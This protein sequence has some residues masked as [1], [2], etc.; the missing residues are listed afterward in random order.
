MLTIQNASVYMINDDTENQAHIVNE[1]I[2]TM[3]EREH[4]QQKGVVTPNPN[5]ALLS[6]PHAVCSA[7]DNPLAPST[8]Q[9]INR[10]D[11]DGRKNTALRNFLY[12]KFTGKNMNDVSEFIDAV[13][14]FLRKYRTPDYFLYPDLGFSTAPANFTMHWLIRINRELTKDQYKAVMQF[15]IRELNLNLSKR[16]ITTIQKHNSWIPVPR[17]GNT[18]DVNFTKYSLNDVELPIDES[19]LDQLGVN[20]QQTTNKSNGITYDPDKLKVA[21]EHFKNQA[22]TQALLADDEER[23]HFFSSIVMAEMDGFVSGS[24]SQ[25]AIDTLAPDTTTATRWLSEFKDQQ[26]NLLNNPDQRL[27]TRPIGTYIPLYTGGQNSSGAKNIAEQLLAQLG[28]DFVADPKLELADA[29]ELISHVYPPAIIKQPGSDKDNVVIFN[30]LTGVWTHDEDLFYSLLT[31]IR[32][33]STAQQL[34]TLMRTFAAQARNA[35]RY[36]RPYSGSR[37]LLF[38]NGVL[39]IQDMQLH[40]VI[41]PFVRDLYFTERSRLNVDYVNNPPLPIR[42]GGRVAGGDW[43]P[44]DFINAYGNN[45]P[46]RV[47][48][49]LFGLSLGLFGGHNFGVHFDIQGE[50]R[51]GKTT[52]SEIFNNLYENRTVIIS[53]TS[54]NGRFPFT[55]YP[56]STSIIWVKECNIGTDPLSDEY[57]TV[58]YDGLADNQVRFE[59]KGGNDIVL[60]NPPQVYIDGT[61][62]I[63]AREINTG[64]AGR[65]LA[66]KLPPMTQELRDQAYANNIVETLH[67]EDVTQWLVYQMIMAY[68][69][70]I[71]ESRRSDLKLN[72]SVKSDLDLL[73]SFAQ[74]WRREFSNDS[75]DLAQWFV[76]EIDPF[77]STDEDNPTLMHNRVL[78]ELYTSAYRR[79]NPHDKN[80]NRIKSMPYFERQL[81]SLFENNGWVIREAGNKSGREKT[82]RKRVSKIDALNFKWAEYETSYTRPKALTTVDEASGGLPGLFKN[83]IPGWFTIERKK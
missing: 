26:K 69:D 39:D 38:K 66:Y 68:R 81:T 64:P 47:R 56:L 80:L 22:N 73:P 9:Q 2:L 63:Q 77:L 16:A 19:F 15:I 53:F 30:P 11:I 28:S 10:A 20:T 3:W 37:Y 12:V 79:L 46:E 6:T 45:D 34:D 13:D 14:S 36:I 52:L 74:E 17:Y 70:T 65:T 71:P 60:T 8:P 75:T 49:F 32:P 78:Y 61:Q 72:L 21:V 1:H 51:W 24:F 42:I 59:V 7:F 43:N 82:A 18:A 33:Y 25:E 31:A 29:C 41:E 4:Q 55:S 48:Y 57:G 76:E 44:E 58:I 23:M 50:S 83:N 54:L 62:L 27:K 5:V 40:N 67:S 35:N